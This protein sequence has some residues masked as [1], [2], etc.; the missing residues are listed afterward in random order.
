MQWNTVDVA[1]LIVSVLFLG[2]AVLRRHL[3]D[4]RGLPPGPKPVPLF[5]NLF[6]LPQQ[7]EWLQFASWGRMYGDVVTM[8]IFN[9]PIIL[10]N[11][12][13]AISDLLDARSGIYSSR[14][15]LTLVND[16]M[17]WGETVVMSPYNER[18]KSYRRLLRS[19][20]SPQVTREYWPLIERE[21]GRELGWLSENPSAYVDH[22][23][24]AAGA[25]ALKIAYGHQKED[26]EFRVLVKDTEE[27]MRMFALAAA[28]GAYLVDTLPI[29][30]YVPVWFP[31]AEFQRMAHR[32]RQLIKTMVDKPFNMV[33]HQ[34][35][36][37]TGPRSFT[38]DLLNGLPGE[39]ASDEDVKWASTA[40]Y[41]GQ[42]DTTI[43][44]LSTFLLCMI[45]F[46]AAQRKAQAEIDK[47]IG[48]DRLP[49]IDDRER[50]PYVGAV[51]KEFLRWRPIV[52]T[53]PHAVTQDDIYLGYHIPKDTPIIGNIWAI[54][55]DPA[56]YP[57]PEE[58]R[59]ERFLAPENAPDSAHFAFGFGRRACPGTAVAHA[60]LFCTVARILAVFN[61]S[62]PE[63]AKEPKLRWSSGATSHPD[64]FD[65]AIEVR[66]P[67]AAALI[68][69]AREA[70][71]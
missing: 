9:K 24:R 48:N 1:A 50:L 62:Q 52:P 46:P 4:R 64:P 59:P 39:R 41:L 66:S 67:A 21:I 30:R 49:N 22:F 31:G 51:I 34:V 15:H 25:M 42:S 8:Q 16:L 36:S 54:M 44:G 40:L 10:L 58:F 71:D 28:P 65:I 60:V 14:P 19:G 68:N 26:D 5:G 53:V 29:L 38:A 12:A 43:A 13:Q 70:T 47:V 56:R 35:D 27:A 17:G 63:G 57:N 55:H 7:E 37:G 45:M 20:L 3:L 32:T 2:I 18:L 6:Q 33:K 11:S 69:R 61:V 23:R